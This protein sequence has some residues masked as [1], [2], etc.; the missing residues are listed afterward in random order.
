MAVKIIRPSL[1]PALVY[2]FIYLFFYLSFFLLK[3]RE[4]KFHDPGKE[5]ECVH[6]SPDGKTLA[7]GGR[8]GTVNIHKLPLFLKSDFEDRTP[9]NTHQVTT[10]KN[11]KK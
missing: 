6:I 11:E 8:D 1:L 3:V 10:K 5:V 2:P 9:K 7:T 4:V